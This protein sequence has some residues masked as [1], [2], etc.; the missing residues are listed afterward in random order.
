MSHDADD[1]VGFIENI[2]IAI[3][4]KP[5][6]ALSVV[7]SLS[8][9]AMHVDQPKEFQEILSDAV[10]EIIEEWSDWSDES[11]EQLKAGN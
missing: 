11:D 6:V 5:D 10:S 7:T 4:R 1:V 2:L 3:T 8:L 9:L